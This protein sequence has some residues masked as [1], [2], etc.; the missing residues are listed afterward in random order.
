MDVLRIAAMAAVVVIHAVAPVVEARTIELGS[1]TWWAANVLDA[2]TRWCVP[3][4]IMVSGALLLD[5]AKRMTV[6]SFY[7]RRV[8]RVGVPL[9][10]WIGCYL[11]FREFYNSDGLTAGQ[12]T[13]AIASGSVFLHLYFLFI[14]LG[15]Y[16][17][18][19]Y[20][21]VLTLHAPRRMLWGFTAMMLGLGVTDQAI[22]T[23]VGQGEPNAVTR[24]LPY[25]GYFVTGWLLRDLRVLTLHAPRRMMWGF[26]AIMLG[27]GITDQTIGTLIGQGQ[28][29]AVTRFLPY[30][31]YFV[32]GWLLRDLRLGRRQVLLAGAGLVASWAAIAVGTGLVADA[33]GW[34]STAGYLYG[35]LSPPV[36]LMSVSAYVL[37]R[38]LG[39]RLMRDGGESLVRRVQSVA[40]LT[41]GVYLVHPALLMPLRRATGIP[42]DVT[43]M[44]A[45]VL[46]SAAVVF[47]ASLALSWLVRRI[48]VLRHTV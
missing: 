13:A 28:P 31:G 42:T 5:P 36:V 23:L 2:S 25:V 24:F 18:T 38:A 3:V 8:H 11:G 1:P 17:V 29:N 16:V 6:R 27:L 47:L 15:L 22:G 9:V 10:A 39:S 40:A 4:F 19:P 30:V 45:V 35:F 46:G 43:G 26:T 37:L 44:L 32:A 48:P 21:R 7:L 12:A 14:L 20:L 41:F 34:N 33:V